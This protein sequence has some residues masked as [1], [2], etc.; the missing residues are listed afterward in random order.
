MS[1]KK[2]IIAKF[3]SVYGVRGWIRVYS[4]TDPP[5]NLLNYP[6]WLIHHQN[7]WQSITIREIKPYNDYF[8]VKLPNCEDRDAAR[9]Y[10]NDL[11]AIYRDELPPLK[12]QEYYW[13][14]LIGLRVI[15]TNGVDL[16]TIKQM[17]A[18]GANDVFVV[19]NDKE[20]LIPYTEDA[21]KSIDLKDKIITVDWD[22]EF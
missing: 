6:N 21:V 19:G 10:T 16:G 20:H 15:T 14:D 18:T 4:F 22:P 3:G 17:L 12:D 9:Q 5:D 2:V 7:T 11:I 13:S 8:I 1:K